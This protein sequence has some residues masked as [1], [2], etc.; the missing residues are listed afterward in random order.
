VPLTKHVGFL[1]RD[2]HNDLGKYNFI[3]RNNWWDTD[4]EDRGSSCLLISA[5]RAISFFQ[6]DDFDGRMLELDAR[7]QF[8]FRFGGAAIRTLH[9]GVPASEPP[10]CV[11]T[12]GTP[13][14]GWG[15]VISSY[16]WGSI[17]SPD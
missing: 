4:I 15:D 9:V 1:V 7:P 17:G 6:H 10:G 14:G 13:S 16:R 2:D 3:V 12:M 5:N 11:S 8:P